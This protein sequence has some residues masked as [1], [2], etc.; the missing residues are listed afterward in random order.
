LGRR[1]IDLAAHPRPAAVAPI[2]IARNAFAEAVP[3]RDLLVSP[4]HAIFVDGVLICARQLINGTTI[5]QITT[6][7]SIEYFHVELD[8]HALLQAEGVPAESYLDTG[9]RGFFSNVGAPLELHPNLTLEATN[10]TREANSCAPF[11][12]DVESVRPVWQRL[13][14][15]ANT[16]AAPM[17]KAR[18]TTEPSLQL[19]V[20]GQPIRPIRGQASP[21][22]FVL[23]RDTVEVHLVSRAG[24][25]TDARPW[26]GDH[27]QLGVRIA[28]I[29]L[30]HGSGAYDMP[31]DSP[32]LAE[33]W[34][35][36]EQ[37]GISM[38]RWTNG[39]AVLPLPVFPG[40]SILE[41]HLGGEMTYL[42]DSSVAVGF[43]RKLAV[44][45]VIAAPT[46]NP[47]RC[48]SA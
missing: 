35:A 33:G 23:P 13:T 47:A 16:I 3:R 17:A 43:T 25:P 48:R 6:Y 7:R 44:P 8:A 37:D 36:V 29:V 15:R 39:D 46:L 21:V 12:S 4:D 11:V 24:S 14:D 18:T 22:A 42:M 26:L 1:R 27:R 5:R 32:D 2:R 31:L 10:P 40:P 45:S 19:V 34:W 28:R 38:R 9:N 41:V 30:R 20:D